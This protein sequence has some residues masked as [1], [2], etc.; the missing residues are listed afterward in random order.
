MSATGKVKSSRK[1][2]LGEVA[3]GVHSL[4][5][6]LFLYLPLVVIVL[7]SFNANKIATWPIQD[8]TLDW[9][10]A[11]RVDR[12]LIAGIKLSIR[13]GIV[14][15]LAAVVLGTLAALA[16]DRYD[17]PGKATLRFLI[18]LP[19]TLPGIVT[20]VAL[21]SYFTLIGLPLSNWTIIIG[22]TT[23]CITLVLNTVVGRLSQLPPH[24]GEA[25]ADLGA[26]PL[27][28]FWRVTLP[29]ILPAILA[30]GL[31]AFTLSFDEV[32]VSLFLKGRDQTLPL[33]IYG[34]LRRGLSP[35]VNA[36]A[37]MIILVSLTG[38]VLSTLLTRRSR[39]EGAG[40]R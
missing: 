33:I 8:Y 4:L 27:R 18:V 38:I 15:A 29:L 12:E 39:S 26:T 32:I 14:S 6:Y 24:L 25:S 23:F 5:L 28:T 31:L 7:Y 10:R 21:L 34:R 3:L 36:A 40:T 19:I 11:L 2:R 37:T 1:L 22:H 17:F 16:I 35:V 30:G 20:G 9:Y 13:V